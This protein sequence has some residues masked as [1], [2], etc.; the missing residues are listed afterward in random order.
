VGED[1]KK[2]INSKPENKSTLNCLGE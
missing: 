1:L 2:K